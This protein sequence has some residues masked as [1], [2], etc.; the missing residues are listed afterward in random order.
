MFDNKS[1][2]SY[3]FNTDFV[4]IDL[5]CIHMC[6]K[7]FCNQQLV[8]YYLFFYLLALVIGYVTIRENQMR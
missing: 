3:Q 8:W 1:R 6:I 2:L 7:S 5:N 4:L